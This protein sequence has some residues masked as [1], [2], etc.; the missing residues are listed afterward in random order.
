MSAFAG[1]TLLAIDIRFD[2]AL[3]PAAYVLY[4]AANLQNLDSEFVSGYAR[5]AEKRHFAEETGDVC[6][7]NTDP[8][9]A[10]ESFTWSGLSWFRDFQSAPELR[11]FELQCLH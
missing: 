3:I 2:R 8:S 5:I 10:D 4:S 6:P 11:L 7:A 1:V 9:N